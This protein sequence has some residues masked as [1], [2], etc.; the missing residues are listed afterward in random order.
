M[1][2]KIYVSTTFIKDK[3][4]VLQAINK[5]KSIKIKNVEIGSNHSYE[6]NYLNLKKFN[7][8]LLIHN[9]FPVPKEEIIINV[10]SQ[11][12]EIRK[13]SIKQIKKS[14]KYA[15][16]NNAK[17]YTFHPGF[18]SD[19]ISSSKKKKNYDF[20]WKDK[21]DKK[22]IAWLNMI[23]SIREIVKFSKKLKFPI[24]IETQGSI[25]NKDKLLMQKPIEFKKFYKLF[26]PR[27]IGI[28]LNL[29]HLNLASKAFKFDK[30]KFIQEI[31]KYVVA[32][33]MSHN[34]GRIDN[35][36]PL[37]KDSWYLSVA[38]NKDFNNIPKILEF[39]NTPLS[40]IKKSYNLFN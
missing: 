11:N 8:N 40:E 2:K 14:I 7:M 9:Y 5:L 21:A 22:K 30:F 16:K 17:L 24:C 36:L 3:Q 29:A 27:D 26:D 35:H 37:K 34:Y 32:I 33:E 31:K 13:K 20:L 39:R 6:R 10:A 25:K 1:I 18:I 28:N 38:K 15:K 4:T 23:K 19:P 12:K